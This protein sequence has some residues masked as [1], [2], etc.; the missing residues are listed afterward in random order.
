MSLDE[1]IALV[2]SISQK[3]DTLKQKAQEAKKKIEDAQVSEQE[4]REMSESG[5]IS[6]L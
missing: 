2:D 5:D 1:E 4:T 3:A 6:Y